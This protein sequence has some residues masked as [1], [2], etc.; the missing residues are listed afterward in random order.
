MADRV[1]IMSEDEYD[2][3]MQGLDGIPFTTDRDE[4]SDGKFIRSTITVSKS[5]LENALRVREYKHVS[6]ADGSRINWDANIVWTD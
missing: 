3:A 4:A 1:V 2:M 5:A 6:P